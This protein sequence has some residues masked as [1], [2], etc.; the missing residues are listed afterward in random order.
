M[1]EPEKTAARRFIKR[2]VIQGGLEAMSLLSKTGV[3]SGARGRGAIFTL[4][5]V[6]PAARK[7]FDPAAHLS[8]TPEFLDA[9]ITRLKA[10]GHVPVALEDLPEY[11]ARTD[12]PG[13]AMV[14]TLD[15]GY[16]DNDLYARPVFEKHGVP[17]TIFIAGGFVDRTHSI[18][19]ETAERLINKL[20]EFTFDY[21]SGEITVP[22]RNLMEKY[23]A[24]S[25]LN[26]SLVCAEQAE[27][28]SRLDAQARAAGI[29]PTGIIDREVMD[30]TELR[31]LAATPL[32]RL[33]AHTISH[34]N[35]AHSKPEQMRAEISLSAERVAEITGETPGTFAYP[36]GDRCAA[37]PREY[38]AAQ[39]L[40][41]KVAVTT[42]P[43]VLQ[44]KSLQDLFSLRRISLNGYYQK[45]RY[46]A[47]LAS[48]IPFALS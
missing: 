29:C 2:T 41:F 3:M 20:D 4:H 13:P 43:G 40:G 14:F 48:G 24:F 38:Q 6:R 28:V 42:N 39:D 7:A 8:V 1:F 15:D 17:Y 23:A 33:G 27:I 11:L 37:G 47:A 12:Q 22:T 35:L 25:R 5:H 32:A 19:W 34:P 30:E 18:W 44:T 16:R 10:D 31:R 26:A 45:C 21:G 9:S 46:V 36:Y